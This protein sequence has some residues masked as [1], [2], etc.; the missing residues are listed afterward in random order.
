MSAHHSNSFSSDACSIC[1]KPFKPNQNLIGCDIGEHWIHRKCANLTLSDFILLANCDTP[2]YCRNCLCFSLPFI[3][4]SKTDFKKLFGNVY[5]SCSRNRTY[6][7]PCN[8]CS[9]PCKSNQNSIYCNICNNWVHQ[10][11]ASLSDS[12]FN[13]LAVNDNHPY[14]CRKCLMDTLPFQSLSNEDL[15]IVNNCNIYDSAYTKTANSIP[16][17]ITGSNHKQ[18]IELSKVQDVNFSFSVLYLNIR[19]LNANFNKLHN[20]LASMKVKPDVIG[21]SETWITNNRPFIHQ[22]EGYNFISEKSP[23]NSGGVGF[24]ILDFHSYSLVNNYKLNVNNTE[25]MWI[26]LKLPSNKL[27]T[28]GNIYRHPKHKFN[29]FHDNIVRV[30]NKLEASKRS[31]IFG[32]DINIDLLKASGNTMIQ[33]FQ[34][35]L[36]SMGCYQT[37]NAA[38][39]FSSNFLTSSLLDHVYTNIA[40][41]K[42]IT[43]IILYDISDHLPC[44]VFIKNMSPRSNNKVN[45]MKQ[46]FKHFDESSFLTDLDSNLSP[47]SKLIN[48]TLDPNNLWNNF[49]QIFNDTVYSHAPIRKVTRK[50]RKF[51]N[52]PW[53]TKG[54][55]KSIN[56]KN[57]MFKLAVS[58]KSQKFSSIFKKYR[59]LLTRVQNLSKKLFYKRSIQN[60]TGNS[61]KLWSVINNIISHKLPKSNH[62]GKVEDC[63]GDIITDPITI[64]NTMNDNFIAIADNLLKNRSHSQNSNK[65]YL[66]KNNATNSFFLNPMKIYDIKRFIRNMD[67][68]KSCRSDAPK[69]SFIKLSVDII[70]PIITKIFNLCI[71]KGV[72]PESLKLAEVIPIYKSGKKSNINN[73]RPISLLSPFSKIFETHICNQLTSYL[74]KNNILHSFQYGFREDSSTELAVTEIVDDITGALENKS[75]NCSVFLDLAKAFNTVNHDI[76]LYKLDTYGVRGVPLQLIQDFLKDRTQC[77]SVNSYKSNAKHIN[78]GVPQGSSLGPLL[79]LLYINDLPTFTNLKVRLFA[80]DACVSFEHKDPLFVEE[81]VNSE[82]EKIKNWLNTNKLF[83][84]HAKS[85]F[86]IFSNLQLKHKFSIKLDNVEI[87]QSHSTKYL[88]VI[89]DDKLNWRE[90]ISSLKSR[91]ARNSYA[92]AKLKPYLDEKTLKMVYYSLIYPHLQYCISS[93]G[94]AA[95]TNLD[96]VIKI[97]KRVVRNICHKSSRS[98][99]HPLFLRLEL[100]KLVDIRKLQTAKLMF[101]YIDGSSLGHNPTI[102]LTD[103]H[104]HYTRLAANDNYYA[105]SATTEPGLRRFSYTG[106]TLWKQVPTEL[107]DKNF[108]QFKSRYK[109]YLIGKYSKK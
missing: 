86:L 73:Y 4:V 33:D 43:N 71:L 67:E 38:T 42:V 40:L 102:K 44:I 64:S 57:M 92:V 3:N 94:Y 52:K 25:D 50:E 13:W 76:L 11:C 56:T 20:L 104:H 100:L 22:L 106:P 88:G 65:Q 1:T 45:Y 108:F 49:E 30:V 27:I 66:P 41:D 59:N 8:E 2:F 7:H 14:F 85:N 47:F 24:F 90:H 16:T 99:T 26:E 29:E 5:T 9:K 105:S 101:K 6:K 28:I 79:F 34:D 60:S 18:Y 48:T 15:H 83:I 91:L 32:G 62:I 36:L 12:Q 63:D 84:N 55:I 58:N 107:K 75:I 31:Y 19:S 46:D 80:D 77:T 61:K 82:L 109:D 74:N 96:P 69:I 10:V 98:H 95:P 39:R 53:L 97:Q 103:I 17:S 81:V 78:V 89:I 70:A 68:K 51:N 23:S 87:S 37:V 54:I 35:S 72:F 93:W 21:V